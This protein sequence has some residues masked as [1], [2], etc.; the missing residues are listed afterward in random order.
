MLFAWK[1][2]TVRL[3]QNSVD[4]F[5]HICAGRA[6]SEFPVAFQDCAF[7][8]LCQIR[9]ASSKSASAACAE[10]YKIFAVQVVLF[11]EC[12]D[13]FW[14]ESPPDWIRDN[15][16]AVAAQVDR[17]CDCRPAFIVVVF[18]YAARIIVSPVQVRTRIFLR[19]NNFVQVRAQS[20]S[21]CCCHERARHIHQRP[22]GFVP[23]LLRCA[24]RI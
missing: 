9:A 15:H 11:N 6:S 1:W 7:C 5:F 4:V 23:F 14:S 22:V 19:R 12:V 17:V 13:D 20:R 18:F 3:F 10:R 21:R 16:V 24:Q 2:H 8:V